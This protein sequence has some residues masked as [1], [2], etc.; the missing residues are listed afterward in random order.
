MASDEIK[1][2]KGIPMPARRGTTG[3]AWGAMEIGDSA[4]IPRTNVYYA[5]RGRNGFK[6][7]SRTVT[8]NGVKGVRVW[9]IA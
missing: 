3:V 7:R 9:R 8:E 2:E 4:F 6:F 1:I 5:G